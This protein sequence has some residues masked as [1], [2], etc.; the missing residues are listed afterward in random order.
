VSL[1][2]PKLHPT[3]PRRPASTAKQGDLNTVPRTQQ[4]RARPAQPLGV[5]KVIPM[6]GLME[7]PG[8]Y[9]SLGTQW[10]MLFLNLMNWLPELKHIELAAQNSVMLQYRTDSAWMPLAGDWQL[11][12]LISEFNTSGEDLRIRCAPEC[13]FVSDSG[14]E[15]NAVDEN[16]LHS[17][18]RVGG[19]SA[20]PT[21][22]DRVIVSYTAT[23]QIAILCAF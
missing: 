21:R 16:I 5:V 15:G 23:P 8:F 9:V 19:S 3:A 17:Y 10:D 7:F 12:D 13:E 6:S 11:N 4:T 20:S 14:G 1:E 22:K 18:N 2:N